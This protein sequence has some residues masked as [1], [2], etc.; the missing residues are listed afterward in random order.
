[1][2]SLLYLRATPPLP[3]SVRWAHLDSNRG[4]TGY[5]PAAL[6]AEL[7]AHGTCGRSAEAW[8]SVF[9]RRAR[10][11]IGQNKRRSHSRAVRSPSQ[12]R[13]DNDLNRETP[14]PR[15]NEPATRELDRGQQC[16]PQAKD[17]EGSA[18]GRGSRL[19]RPSQPGVGRAPEW[20]GRVGEVCHRRTV[21]STDRRCASALP[22]TASPISCATCHF[23]TRSEGL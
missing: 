22:T 5:E 14:A 3:P 19:R 4:P 9:V 10:P 8:S 12:H 20:A 13:R 2:S 21:H 15:I 18:A 1:M 16:G 6:T 17:K 23:T 11:T 7:W